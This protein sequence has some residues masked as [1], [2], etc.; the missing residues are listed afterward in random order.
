MYSRHILKLYQLQKMLIRFLLLFPFIIILSNCT[1]QKEMPVVYEI[2]RDWFFNKQGTKEWY[3]AQVPGYIH[4]DLFQ[5]GLIP[6][7]FYRLNEREVQWIENE[8]WNYRTCFDLPEEFT[9]KQKIEIVFEGLDTYAE[10]RLND[11]LLLFADNMFRSWKADITGLIREKDNHLNILFHSPIQYI[12]PLYYRYGY[13]IP[14][15]S[16]QP[17]T[18]KQVDIKTS[19][20]T[21]KAQFHYGWDWAPRMVTS[22]IWRPVR[23]IGY[24]LVKIRNIHYQMETVD[25]KKAKYRVTA[26]IE[27]LEE[28]QVEIRIKD[29]TNDKNLKHE[30]KNLIPGLNQFTIDMII[31]KP[32]LW[33]PNGMGDQTLYEL[34]FEVYLGHSIIERKIDKIGIRTIEVVREPDSIGTSFYFRVNGIPVFIKGA[35][36]VPLDVFFPRVNNEKYET[37]IKDIKAGN[38]NMLRVWGG[39]IYENDIFYK[40]CD[41]YGILIWQDFMFSNSMV[42]G[43][44]E[45]L[46]NISAE[47]NEVVCA[48][49]N[50]PC[51][52]MYCG[53]NEVLMFW[54]SRWKDIRNKPEGSKLWK[55]YEEIFYK[56]LPGAVQANDPEKFYWPSSPS[57]NYNEYD[58]TKA[59]T[60]GNQHFW[61]VYF[62][63]QPKELF[64]ERKRMGRFISEY[65]LQ[66]YPSLNN[67]RT[68]ALPEDFDVWSP[69]ML[70]HHKLRL[71]NGNE[72][73]FYHILLDYPMPKDFTSTLYV[74]QVMQAEGI[75]VAA[76]AHRRNR[77]KTMGSLY[78]QAND[79]WPVTSWSG[80]D[81][82]GNW[83]PLQYYV[84]RAYAP[85]LVSPYIQENRI[86]VAVVSDLREE[87]NYT[88]KLEIMDFRGNIC[89][90][91]LKD[92]RVKP[93]ASIN[94]F[95]RPLSE[96]I[97]IQ[98]TVNLFLNAKLMDGTKIISSNQL[99]FCKPKHLSLPRPKIST[100]FSPVKE[101]ILITLTSDVLAKNVYMQCDENEGHFQDNCFNLLPGEI[102]EITFRTDQLTDLNIFRNQF[103][104]RTLADAFIHETND[105]P[106]ELVHLRPYEGNPVFTSGEDGAWDSKIRGRGYILKEEDG[107]HMWYTGYSGTEGNTKFLGY[108]TSQNG[109]NWTRYPGNP[110]YDDYWTEDVFVVKNEDT[111]YMFAEGVDDISHMLTST[112]RVNW[113]EHGNLDIRL[114]NGELLPGPYGSPTVWIEGSR[115]YLFYERKD[116]GIWIASTEDLKTWTN[117]LDEPVIRVGPDAFDHYAIALNQVIRYKGKYYA[118]YHS[119]PLPDWSTWDTHIAV[120]D[121]LIHWYI[122]PGNP[123]ITGDKSSGIYVFDG[124]VYRLYTMH[125]EMNVYLPINNK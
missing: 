115:W 28:K 80:I 7:P 117:V 85:V 54:E 56:I 38:M 36:Y 32:E 60:S 40:L 55:A 101:G 45:F 65:G 51:I 78:W 6:D 95:S 34:S 72:N 15:N 68:F 62:G 107:Y 46:D 3:P 84:M 97:S 42:R 64:A 22:G 99:F 106:E 81:Y 120:S 93:N 29:L 58:D 35:N 92:I 12:L 112:D 52:A 24:D 114:T 79:C 90:S 31:Q 4:T 74:S 82:Y 18:E 19:T 121:D 104:I 118:I 111:Y 16:E 76:E 69:V 98:D 50:H 53:N 41:Q 43:D 14:V 124:E 5:N 83:K 33:W 119:T 105:F 59:C 21:R 67:I 108:A 37:F 39:G 109:Y 102:R 103:Y 96:L 125:P 89:F 25:I 91:E 113:K 75:K 63:R 44:P 47:A 27:S 13:T 86:N 77:D 110:V 48:L 87:K 26:E 49:R 61:Y 123:I 17:V 11:S 57:S 73:M 100:R 122:Y 23:I 66:S 30:I 2:N 70:Q 9:A 1:R 71:R 20:F 10:V 8:N 88:L 116:L 94:F